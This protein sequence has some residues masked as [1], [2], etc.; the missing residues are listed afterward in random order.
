MPLSDHKCVKNAEL[1]DFKDECTVKINV[2]TA[3]L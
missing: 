3:Y 1:A 2:T